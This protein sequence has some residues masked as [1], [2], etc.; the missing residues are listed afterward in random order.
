M[1]GT[2]CSSC[3]HYDMKLLV[4]RPWSDSTAPTGGI[5]VPQHLSSLMTEA[6]VLLGGFHPTG[7]RGLLS[8]WEGLPQFSF[9]AMLNG[10]IIKKI[11]GHSFQEQ[12][13]W[14][15]DPQRQEPEPTSLENAQPCDLWLGRD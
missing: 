7:Y 14:A 3:R 15:R 5:S 2:A 6:H 9:T 11:S 1:N 13:K 10:K 8:S 4:C 12:Q